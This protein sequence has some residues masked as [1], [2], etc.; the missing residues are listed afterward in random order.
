MANEMSPPAP[1]PMTPR[2]FIARM[3][4]AAPDLSPEQLLIAARF[5]ENLG[6]QSGASKQARDRRKR[7]DFERQWEETQLHGPDLERRRREPA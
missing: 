7:R 6:A 3:E 2:D 1:S 4:A 5:V